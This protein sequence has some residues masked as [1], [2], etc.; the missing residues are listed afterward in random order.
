MKNPRTRGSILGREIDKRLV[1]LGLSRREFA[2]RANIGRQTLQDIIHDPN[3]RISERTFAALDHG[4]KWEAGVSKAFHAGNQQARDKVG[5]MS[6]DERING[7]LL[8]ILQR[9]GEM[10]IDQLE[11][12]VLL[13]EE[14]SGDYSRDS[15]TSQLIERQIRRLVASLLNPNSGGNGINGDECNETSEPPKRERNQTITAGE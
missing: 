4:L 1:Q 3:K 11:R 14:E 6:I 12:E 7:Y 5:A 8:Q 13:L 15:E 2:R 10:N 9:L